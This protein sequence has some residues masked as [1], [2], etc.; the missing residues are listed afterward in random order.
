MVDVLFVAFFILPEVFSACLTLIRVP[1]F[2]EIMKESKK[3]LIE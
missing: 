2:V 3:R 1:H